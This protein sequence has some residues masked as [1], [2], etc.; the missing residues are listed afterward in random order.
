[1]ENSI[2]NKG[3]QQLSVGDYRG[4][5]IAFRFVCASS[6][7]L[8]ERATATQGLGISLFFQQNFEAAVHSLEKSLLVVKD[9]LSFVLLVQGYIILG[10]LE[11][12]TTKEKDYEVYCRQYKR[13]LIKDE[14][15]RHAVLLGYSENVV[16][17][18]FKK[19]SLDTLNDFQILLLN[20]AMSKNDKSSFA[21]AK[22]EL[23][24]RSL[25]PLLNSYQKDLGGL[26]CKWEDIESGKYENI[27]IQGNAKLHESDD[28]FY[29]ETFAA[30]SLDGL[31]A[32]FGVYKGEMLRRLAAFFYDQEVFGFDSFKGLPS[33]WG[34]MLPKG[35]FCLDTIPQFEEKNIEL[36]IGLFQDTLPIFQKDIGSKKIKFIHVDCDLYSSTSTVL[37]TLKNNFTAGSII[38]FDEYY[39]YKGWMDHEYRAFQEL[40]E[41]NDLHYEYVGI[42]NAMVAVR[43]L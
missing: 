27:M 18:F 15:G 13:I 32:E 2:L 10:D 22:S 24:R 16:N 8:L 28:S 35:H 31:V 20:S 36:R 43:L 33:D 4:A 14:I 23:E 26:F 19:E 41:Q 7:Y 29:N 1:M 34:E 21:I 12:A 3:Y 39:N 11:K 9:R 6:S 38:L 5:E 42:R 30:A 17:F 37:Q 25:E 40:V